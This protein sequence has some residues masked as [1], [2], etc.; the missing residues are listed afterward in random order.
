MTNKGVVDWWGHR[1]WSREWAISDLF[2]GWHVANEIAKTQVCTNSDNSSN[3]CKT[4][5]GN[6]NWQP[7]IEINE[8]STS[9]KYSSSNKTTRVVL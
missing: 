4:A 9:K 7:E 3:D 5:T 8:Y 6:G 2:S 1:A